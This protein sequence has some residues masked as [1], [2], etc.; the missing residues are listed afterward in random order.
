MVI[1]KLFVFSSFPLYV[2]SNRKFYKLRLID[3]NMTSAEEH[4]KS[5]KQFNEDIKEKIR[6]GLLIERQKIIAFDASEASTNLLE[7]FLHKKNLILAGFKVNHNYFASLKRAHRYFDFDFP[8]KD[9]IIALMVNQEEFRNI[10]CY[11]KEKDIGEIKAVI[12]NLNK[13]IELI[14]TE[15]GEML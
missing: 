1:F 3:K 9:E 6:A 4:L 11:G 5:F 12:D 10:L 7:Y 14:K 2:T 13:L 8:R 15:L